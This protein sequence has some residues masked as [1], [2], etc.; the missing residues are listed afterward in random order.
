MNFQPF[1][2]QPKVT[3][4]FQIKDNHFVV[5]SPNHSYQYAIHDKN[6]PATQ[7]FNFTAHSIP[8]VNDWVVS[9]GEKVVCLSDSSFRTNYLVV[10]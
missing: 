9:D 6:D 1:V 4:A 8:Q 5:Q 3:Y 7:V 10:R 2:A